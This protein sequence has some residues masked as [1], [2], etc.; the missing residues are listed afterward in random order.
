ML[1]CTLT[2]YKYSILVRR[3]YLWDKFLTSK[4]KGIDL[5][6]NFESAIKSKL[7]ELENETFKTSS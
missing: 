5:S 2:K 1:K 7:V 6:I 3:P 4:E